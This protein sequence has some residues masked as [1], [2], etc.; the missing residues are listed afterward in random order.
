[1]ALRL[2]L[3]ERLRVE[4]FL[5]PLDVVADL[6]QMRLGLGQTGQH[7]LALAFDPLLLRRERLPLLFRLE[8]LM[9][10]MGLASS[11]LMVGFAILLITGN[12][13]ALTE[14]VYQAIPLVQIR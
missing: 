2:G 7:L 11:I 5:Q 8:K 6:I 9:P 14:W 3:I 13:M 10:W 12:Y 4:L 1:M